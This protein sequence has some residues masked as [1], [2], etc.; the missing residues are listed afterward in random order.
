M[1]TVESEP[2]LSSLSKQ[3]N[4]KQEPQ[5]QLQPRK[6]DQ[7]QPHGMEQIEKKEKQKQKTRM[8]NLP[9]RIRPKN[10]KIGNL[11]K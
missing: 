1:N 4:Q 10:H 3:I 7:E 2:I 5:Q 6:Q 8:T 9:T 11:K